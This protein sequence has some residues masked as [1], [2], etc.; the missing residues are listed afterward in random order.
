[1]ICRL[2]EGSIIPVTLS[3][4]RLTAPEMRSGEYDVRKVDVWAA[5]ATVWEMAESEPPFMGMDP[6][7]MPDCLPALTR[8]NLYSSSFHDFLSLCSSPMPSRPTANDLLMVSN[9]SFVIFIFL[10]MMLTWLFCVVDQFHQISMQSFFNRG[11][12]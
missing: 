2:S 11:P 1:M 5:G 3:P 9:S 8:S 4:L 7:D 6:S 10:H 12:T